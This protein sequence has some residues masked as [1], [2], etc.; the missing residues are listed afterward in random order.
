MLFSSQRFVLG[1]L[2]LTLVIFYSTAG[3]RRAR[4]SVIIIASILFYGFF[5]WRFVRLLVGLGLA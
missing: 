2:P 3:N 5:E 4:Q 1:F